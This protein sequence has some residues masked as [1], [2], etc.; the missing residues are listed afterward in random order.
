MKKLII[1]S[2]TCLFIC[3]MSM[4]A[5]SKKENFENW[6][7]KMKAEK[8]AFITSYVDLTVEE[9][10]N[11]WPIYNGIEKKKDELTLCGMLRRGRCDADYPSARPLLCTCGWILYDDVVWR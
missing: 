7:E 9:A 11:F 6:R 5:Q 10:Q 4:Q 2:L 3:S 1:A 8:V